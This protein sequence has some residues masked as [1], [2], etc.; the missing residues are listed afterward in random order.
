MTAIDR[1]VINVEHPS[2][3]EIRAVSGGMSVGR[4]HFIAEPRISGRPRP[5][6]SAGNVLVVVHKGQHHRVRRSALILQT[7]LDDPRCRRLTEDWWRAIELHDIDR[8]GVIVD[9]VLDPNRPPFAQHTERVGMAWSLPRGTA[10][11][12]AARSPWDFAAEVLDAAGR[13][14]DAALVQQVR[15]RIDALPVTE[16]QTATF[17]ARTIAEAYAIVGQLS[18][19]ARSFV[20]EL[21]R[22]PQQDVDE[23]V[24]AALCRLRVALAEAHKSD[25]HK[26]RVLRTYAQ[27]W[28]PDADPL[29]LD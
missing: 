21:G 11:A 12:R 19:T 1:L 5:R 26:L 15:G 23:A 20:D 18:P 28:R 8:L 6:P 4:P 22:S 7:G 13:S 17:A 14:S 29:S 27:R 10:A 24:D 2:Q 3:T 25:V 16:Q 9:F